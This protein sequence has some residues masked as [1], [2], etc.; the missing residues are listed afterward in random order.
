MLI[1]YISNAFSFGVGAEFIQYWV[2]KQAGE[3]TSSESGLGRFALLPES[4]VHWTKENK[5]DMLQDPKTM[6]RLLNR[7]GPYWDT[8]RQH[9]R[10]NGLINKK[11][12]LEKSPQNGVMTS[13]LEGLYNT[14]V[15]KDGSVD[16]SRN[17]K[18]ARSVT[19]F[20]FITRDPIANVYA[21]D[22]F[23]RDA[24]GGFVNFDTL[25]QNYIQ[26]HEYMQ[27]DSKKIDS[28]FMWVRLEDFVSSPEK[29]LTSIFS[30]LGVATEEN[31]NISVASRII[32]EFDRIHS[33][34][35]KKYIDH[36]CA[37]GRKEHEDLLKYKSKIRGLNLGYDL[38]KLCP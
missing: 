12:W 28:E 27:M 3:G 20:L 13:F 24:M 18:S 11:V 14:P 33:D 4:T 38:T 25:M 22:K 1:F 31:D 10:T 9:N 16:T 32:G 26:L 36:W 30:F 15:N 21:T 17:L 7:F 23:I 5:Q 2:S 8:S 34:P 35:N 6:S 19:K 37:E 29:T